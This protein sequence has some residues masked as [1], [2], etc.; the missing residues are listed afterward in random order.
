MIKE[1]T[2]K[3]YAPASNFHNWLLHYEITQEA[4]DEEF[5]GDEDKWLQSIKD[6][7]DRYHRDDL[8]IDEGTGGNL[9]IDGDVYIDEPIASGESHSPRVR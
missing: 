9:E 1:K 6:G 3:A 4:L 5:D 2:I 8:M 7:D